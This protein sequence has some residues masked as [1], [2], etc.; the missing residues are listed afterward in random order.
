VDLPPKKAAVFYLKRQ[1]DVQ[2]HC[3]G[4]SF[5]LRNGICREC[6][7]ADLKE[8][9]ISLDKRKH[10]NDLWPLPSPTYRIMLVNYKAKL[11]LPGEKYRHFL[12]INIVFFRLVIQTYS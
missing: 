12:N 1:F 7:A 6:A 8:V 9:R 11:S 3:C 4:E 10:V 5:W 2:L